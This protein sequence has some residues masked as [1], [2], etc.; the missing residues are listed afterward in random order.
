MSL[1]DNSFHETLLLHLPH[2]IGRVSLASRRRRR[3]GF[4][5]QPPLRRDLSV[6]SKQQRKHGRGGHKRTHAW[7]EVIHSDWAGCE[8]RGLAGCVGSVGE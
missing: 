3:R 2:K 4:F 6:R 5:R 1:T 8:A 7:G